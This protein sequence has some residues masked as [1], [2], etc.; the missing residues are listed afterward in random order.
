MIGGVNETVWPQSA[1]SDPW[2]SR[3]MKKDFGFPLPEK[4]IGILALD[5]CNLLAAPEVY[6]TRAD[7]VE[8]TPMVKSRWLMRLETVL[9]ALN[10]NIETIEMPLYRLLA[11]R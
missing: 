11:R 6:L 7:R 3:P 8:G 9:K 2:L 10:L 5:F 1:G 4:A